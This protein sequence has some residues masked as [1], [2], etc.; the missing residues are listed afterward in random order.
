MT[1][2]AALPLL[3][4]AAAG[5]HRK[6]KAVAEE[7]VQRLEGFSLSQSNHGSPTWDLTARFAQLTDADKHALLEKPA[8][9]FYKKRK[10]VSTVKAEKGR[11]RTDTYDV[12]L[13]CEVVVTSLEDRTVLKT[14]ELTYDSTARKFR[15]NHDV[16][17]T[18]PGGSLRGTGLE[19]SPDLSDIRIFNQRTVI[20]GTR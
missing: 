2:V 17:V 16:V 10:E 9:S 7:P 18:R 11:V 14:E 8:L 3:V 6:A 15:T 12:V 5:C 13:S 20:E 1:R 4:L 19:A